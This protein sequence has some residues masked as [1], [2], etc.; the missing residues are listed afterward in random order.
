MANLELLALDEATPQIIAPT[1]S[2][3]GII[4]GA[5]DVALDITGETINAD[6]V[7]SAG[8][9]AAMGFSATEGLVLTGQG[10]VNDI[11]LKNDLDQAVMNIATGGLAVEFT[12][13]VTV[14]G[15]LSF[16]SLGS[17]VAITEGGTGAI[18][19]ADARTNLGVDAAGTDNSVD[20][21]LAGTPDYLT[22]SGQEI[23]LGSVDL[24]TDIT[25]N[26]SVNNLN[27][28][29]DASATSFWRGDGVWVTPAG[30]GNVS[31]SGTPVIDDIPRFINATDIEGRSAAEFKADLD[32]E[33]GV[34]LQA[35]NAGISSVP[36]IQGKETIWIP[37]GTMTPL[38][39]NG[40]AALAQVEGTAGRP[41]QQ[42]LDFDATT[43]E[44]VQFSVS[45]PKSWDKGT[46]SFQVFWTGLAGAGGVV[47]EMEGVSIADD[48]PIDTV[49]GT[50]VEITDT[51]IA[52]DDLM[53]SA[54]SGAITI[55]GTPGDDELVYFKFSR[56]P[57]NASDTRAVDSNVLG[58]K[59]F[60]TTD[61]GNDA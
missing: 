34:D 10:S 26:L 50:P 53:V 30:G 4:V 44:S 24:S 17:V 39:T 60:F 35:F 21:T 51:F 57:V 41:E 38:T 12:G 49:Y 33:V 5:L 8:D 6:G 45:F 2:D 15:V 9:L 13:A 37:A 31:T 56:D 59:F 19:A 22:I 23:T 7:T 40:S 42:T 47:W 36:K 3:T 43:A 11:T 54:E 25:G 29:T 14:V 27:S 58:V 20:V 48:D 55:A 18:T 61:A 32:L 16:G 1:A 46:V 52:A 28:G